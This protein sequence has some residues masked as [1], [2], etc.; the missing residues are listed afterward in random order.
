MNDAP[1]ILSHAIN[2][3]LSDSAICIPLFM[4]YPDNWPYIG[5]M[6]SEL[7]ITNFQPMIEFERYQFAVS[8][9]EGVPYAYQIGDITPLVLKSRG[10]T[11]LVFADDK[12]QLLEKLDQL[13]EESGDV[14]S[15]LFDSL[16][17]SLGR[18]SLT[19]LAANDEKF[20]DSSPQ[21]DDYLPRPARL[22]LDESV[23]ELRQSGQSDE[24]NEQ[25]ASAARFRLLN[26]ARD[27]GEDATSPLFRHFLETTQLLDKKGVFT[28]DILAVALLRRISEEIPRSQTATNLIGAFRSNHGRS[29]LF[30]ANELSAKSDG[31]FSERAKEVL[32][33]FYEAAEEAIDQ[34]DL[35]KMLLYAYAVDDDKLWPDRLKEKIDKRFSFFRDQLHSFFELEQTNLESLAKLRDELAAQ[36]LGYRSA[37]D[38]VLTRARLLQSEMAKTRVRQKQTVTVL[39]ALAKIKDGLELRTSNLDLASINYKRLGLNPAFIEY[40]EREFRDFERSLDEQS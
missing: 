26:W 32:D 27:F 22:W 34:S 11:N 28:K 37:D 31:L 40:S 14:F 10:E 7:R 21:E 4:R 8:G 9:S 20:V 19:D 25:E 6:D 17:A 29:P 36:G 5:V 30:F 12:V 3:S 24:I 35:S 15:E 13:S 23:R 1:F 2:F 38:S 39:D 16:L 33:T 18:K